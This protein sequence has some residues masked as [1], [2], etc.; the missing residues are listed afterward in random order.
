MRIGQ[1]PGYE[2][3]NLKGRKGCWEKYVI[4]VF[5]SKGRSASTLSFHP[6]IRTYRDTYCTYF[7]FTS[8]VRKCNIAPNII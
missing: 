8:E 6:F 3:I 5:F 4:D 7:P 1:G 2:V